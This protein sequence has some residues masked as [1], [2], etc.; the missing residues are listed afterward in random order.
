MALATSRSQVVISLPGTP[1]V[2]GLFSL[3]V[4]LTAVGVGLGAVFASSLFSTGVYLLLMVA[5]LG[6]IFTSHIWARREPWNLLL[7]GLFPLLSGITIAPYLWLVA[8]G[9][10]GNTILL[11][12]LLATTFMT[13]ASALIARTYPGVLMGMGGV[14]MTGLIGLLLLG[15]LQIVV[16]ALRLSTGFELA[17]SGGGVLLFATFTAYDL[18]LVRARLHAGVAPVLVALHLYLDI[19]NLFLMIL[20][21]MVALSGARR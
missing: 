12:A 1:Q 3:A 10:F 11:H 20:R 4:G 7:F 17:M 16:P 15:L 2:Y 18:Q 6:L 21:F 13:L 5:E 14:L 8:S 9:P 19:F